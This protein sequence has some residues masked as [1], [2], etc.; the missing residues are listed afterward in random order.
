M[1]HDESSRPPELPIDRVLPR[2]AGGAG[3]ERLPATSADGTTFTVALAET[4]ESTGP[5]VVILPDIRGVAPFYDELAERFA[6]AG[7][8]AIVVDYFGR[9]FPDFP[10]GDDFNGFEAAQRTENDEVQ[11]D[12]AA[13]VAL[14]KERTGV[15]SVVSVGFCFGGSN[16][17]LTAANADAD[18]DGFVAFYGGLNGERLG[19]PS[20]PDHAAEMRGPILGLFG[21]ADQS[22]PTEL[23][24]Q[25]DEALS[26]A[27][28]EHEFVV[29]PGAPHGFF[30][31]RFDE[32]AESCADAWE[33]TLDF[34]DTIDARRS[35][36]RS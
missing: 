28:V 7:H 11:A 12:I 2:L 20:P 16:S 10:R 22:I 8:H 36:I 26:A 25:F 5:G 24:D 17:Y 15:S 1:C 19:I 14:L 34:L 23:V 33:R 29:Y 4:P 13:A 3:A 6:S 18:V 35:A 31:R 32:H 30:D 27:E 21:D 9:T